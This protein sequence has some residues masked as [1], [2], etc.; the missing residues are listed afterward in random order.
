MHDPGH[1]PQQP[2][3]PA[4]AERLYTVNDIAG[5][6]G[7]TPRTI[8]QYLA[9]GKLEFCKIGLFVRVTETQLAAFLA[10]TAT[11]NKSAA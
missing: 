9:D 11:K 5:I 3:R 10:S 4:C 2:M 7:C 1:T 6:V 8:R